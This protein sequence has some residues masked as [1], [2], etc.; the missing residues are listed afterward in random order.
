MMFVDPSGYIDAD[1]DE[2]G[3]WHDWN[4]ERYGVDSPKYK[5]LK[6][7]RVKKTDRALSPALSF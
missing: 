2:N 3:V 4:A 1:Y 7:E 6:L 5:M